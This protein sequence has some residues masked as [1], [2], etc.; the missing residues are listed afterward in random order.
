ML[1]YVQGRE[2]G[3]EGIIPRPPTPVEEAALFLS[4]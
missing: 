4:N 3:T 2:I 1:L